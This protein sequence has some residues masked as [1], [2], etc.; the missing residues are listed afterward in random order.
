MGIKSGAHFEK[1]LVF[2]RQVSIQR[3]SFWLCLGILY[4][5]IVNFDK[6]NDSTYNKNYMSDVY[7]SVILLSSHSFPLCQNHPIVP[8]TYCFLFSET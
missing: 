4:I 3:R 7:I 5:I 6:F 2:I 8:I 1:C